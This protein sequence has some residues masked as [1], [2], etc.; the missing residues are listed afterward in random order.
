MILTVTVP[1]SRTFEAYYYGNGEV[2]HIEPIE[3]RPGDVW[4]RYTVAY[5]DSW[6]AE[7][8]AARFQSGLYC[9]D[10]FDEVTDR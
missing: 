5:D 3:I 8:Q 2:L 4:L 9:A 6:Y 1:D 10:T 7:Y